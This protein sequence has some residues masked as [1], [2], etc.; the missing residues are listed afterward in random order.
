MLSKQFVP[1]VLLWLFKAFEVRS[2]EMINTVP[3]AGR[4]N[5]CFAEFAEYFSLTSVE[6]QSNF[7]PTFS[8]NIL[9]WVECHSAI[10]S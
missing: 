9:H 2:D 8:D 7:C 10:S 6:H 5:N 4:Y 3:L 1:H